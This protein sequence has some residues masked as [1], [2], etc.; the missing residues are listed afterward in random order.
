MSEEIEG[1]EGIEGME[2]VE[3]TSLIEEEEGVVGVGVSSNM[4][5]VISSSVINI[6]DIRDKITDSF[7]PVINSIRQT[8]GC[9]DISPFLAGAV[10]SQ[11][12]SKKEI[13]VVVPLTIVDNNTNDDNPVQSIPNIDSLITDSIALLNTILSTSDDE[14]CMILLDKTMTHID[15]NV[16]IDTDNSSSATIKLN[17][18][19]QYAVLEH[20]GLVIDG[21]LVVQGT[22]LSPTY[23]PAICIVEFAADHDE[24]FSEIA[25]IMPWSMMFSPGATEA[26]GNTFAIPVS[27][28]S[29]YHVGT[30][31]IKIYFDEVTRVPYSDEPEEEGASFGISPDMILSLDFNTRATIGAQ[32][33]DD[34]IV[35]EN[36]NDDSIV[37]KE[38]NNDHDIEEMER[39]INDVSIGDKK[40]SL[41]FDPSVIPVAEIITHVAIATDY[42]DVN[43][44]HQIGYDLLCSEVKESGVENETEHLWKFFVMV[45][46]GPS[47]QPGLED[48]AWVKVLKALGSLPVVPNMEVLHDHDLST[49]DMD[50]SI[51]LAIRIGDNPLFSKLTMLSCSFEHEP[52]L[53]PFLNSKKNSVY[54]P[55]PPEIASLIG[56]HAGILLEVN[57]AINSYRE[58]RM[59]PQN[60][61]S[62]LK[63]FAASPGSPGSYRSNNDSPR[64]DD[65]Y[66]ENTM[67]DLI[68]EQKNLS[69]ERDELLAKNVALQKKAAVL[70]AREKVLQG[71]G[72]G[73]SEAADEQTVD[74]TQEK[75]K[76]YIDTV[77]LI[78]EGR[79]KYDNQQKEFDQL[80]LDL[81]TRL[82]DKEFKA[83][84]IS[85][86]FKA[87]KLEI[88][89]KA[90]NSRTGKPLSKRVIKQFEQAEQRREEDLEKVRLRNITLRTTLKKL[91]RTLRAREQLAEGLHMIDFEQLKVENQTLNEKIEERNEELAKLKRKK[92][93]TVQVLTHV[94]EKLYFMTNSNRVARDEL[95]SLEVDLGGVRNKVTDLKKDRDSLKKDLKS[96]SLQRG[97]AASDLLLVDFDKRKRSLDNIKAAIQEYQDRY[98]ILEKQLNQNNKMLEQTGAKTTTA[99]L[100]K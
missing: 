81:Q 59:S 90:V 70:L 66:E 63:N 3:E 22:T 7:I 24:H 10:S 38:M 25:T 11:Y 79:N 76:Q 93:V 55:A 83:N 50:C 73:P 60:S 64:S 13:V 68:V 54:K 95:D 92:T 49:S 57:E 27:L 12:Y 87:F 16:D 23:G 65:D 71:P 6:D 34:A 48:I 32:G 31:R 8:N 75:E 39:H 96:L 74:Q 56:G 20:V 35:S 69:D 47:N 67:E 28:G 40:L 85:E 89:N 94:R 84:E 21:D 62:D 98:K 14:K 2:G 19:S 53:Q 42:D 5:D 37:V 58:K 61:A 78:V 45:K 77:Q 33:G 44:F 29:D 97:F 82:D 30:V 91:E 80:A 43:H 4:I 1:T 46:Y 36:V 15:A 26:D 99:P 88:L 17:V 52:A 86:S 41:D 51:Y 72:K 100:R 9:N 18:Y